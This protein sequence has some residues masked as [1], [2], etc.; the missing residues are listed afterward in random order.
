MN[1]DFFVDDHADQDLSKLTKSTTLEAVNKIIDAN[2]DPRTKAVGERIK[3]WD[4]SRLTNAET[5]KYVTDDMEELI[6]SNYESI[7]IE[8][9]IKHVAELSTLAGDFTKV[10]DLKIWNSQLN[11]TYLTS[12]DFVKIVG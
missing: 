5:L 4:C 2:S 1:E 11:K 3:V 7:V 12:S 6:L 8:D 10:L 9:R